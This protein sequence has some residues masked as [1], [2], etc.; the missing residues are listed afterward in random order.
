MADDDIQATQVGPSAE[1]DMP[2]SKGT[3]T[4]PLEATQ[5]FREPDEQASRLV[6]V[7]DQYLADLKAGRAPDRAQL[8]ADHPEL[9]EQLEACLAGIE[10]IHAGETSHAPKQLGE[11]RILREIGR[12]GMGAVYEAEQLSLRRRVALKVLRFGTVSDPEAIQRFQREAETVARLH[13]TNIVPIFAV[14]CER[15]VN[16]YAMQF[17]EGRSLDLVLKQRGEPADAQIVATWGLQAADA[18]AHAHARG[19]IHR[20]V[21]PSNLILDDAEGRLWLTDFGLAKRLDDV[22]LSMTG[23]LLGTPRYMSP[24]QAAAAHNKLD[25]RTDIYSLGA[26]LYELATGKPVFSGDSPH[27]VISQIITAEPTPPRKHRP[28]LPR[29]LDTIMMKCLSKEPG[30]RYESA[31]QLADD[32]RAFLEGR[33][34]AARRV[35]LVEQA[36]RWVKRQRRSVALTAGAVAITLLLVALTVAGSYAWHRSRLATAMLRTDFPPLVADLLR[37]GEAALPPVTVPTQHPV[38]TTAGEYELRLS[39]DNRLSETIDVTFVPRALFD[40]KYDLEDQ[41]LWG[42]LRLD[43][44]YRL[45][46]FASDGT[47]AAPPRVDVIRLTNDGLRCVWGTTG[48]D[49]WE[50]KLREPTHAILKDNVR[51]FWPWEYAGGSDYDRGLGAFDKR[52]WVVSLDMGAPSTNSPAPA[53]AT[54]TGWDFN[55]DGASDLVLAAQRQAWVLA[56]SGRDGEPLWVAARGEP[57]LHWNRGEGVVYPPLAVGDQNGDGKTELI[58][59]FVRAEP[60][61]PAERWVE[62]LSSADGKSLWRYDLAP[63]WF[64][65]AQDD[66][67]PY[68]LRWFYGQSGGF[69]S[70]GAGSGWSQHYRTRSDSNLERSGDYAY[71]PTEPQVVSASEP[72]LAL[73]AGAHGVRLDVKSGQPVEPPHDTGVHTGMQPRYGD[74][75]GDGLRDTLLIDRRPDK[76][77]TQRNGFTTNTPLVRLTAWSFVKQTILWRRDLEAAWPKQQEMNLLPPDWPVVADVNGDG[78]DDVLAPDG[79]TEGTNNWYSPPWGKVALLDGGSGEPFWRQQIFNLDQQLDYFT[80]GPDIDGDGRREVYVAALWGDG[81]NLFVDCLS[82]ADG[83]KLWR[84][85]QRLVH[86]ERIEAEYRLANL[87]WFAARGDG[88]PQ[89]VVTARCVQGEA[90]DRASFFSAGTGRLTHQAGQASELQAADL[91]AD[92]VEDLV[93]FRQTNVHN[94]DHGG[95]LQAVRGIGREAWRRGAIGPVAAGDLD[96]DGVR[97]LM[98]QPSGDALR[99]RSGATGVVL[100]Q[101]PIETSAYAYQPFAAAT[102]DPRH[103]LLETPRDLDGDGVPDL[104]VFSGESSVRDKQPILMALS[105]RQGALLWKSDF[106][107]QRSENAVLLDCRDLDGDGKVEV[108]FVAPCDYDQPHRDYFTGTN[109]V[110]L[111]LAVL[112]GRDGGVRWAQPLTGLQSQSGGAHYDLRRFWLDAA[113]ADLNGDGVEDVVLPA[114]RQAGA[115]PL[116]MV[117]HSGSDGQPLWKVPLPKIKDAQRSF[118]LVPPAAAGDLDGDGQPEVIAAA[119]AD[120]TALNGA[121]ATVVRLHA[122]DGKTG[123][124][125]WQWETPADHWKNEVDQNEPGRMKNRLRPIL[126]RRADGKQWVAIAL[127]ANDLQLHVVDDAGKSV[128][129]TSVEQST[130]TRGV[131]TWAIDAEGDGVDELIFLTENSLAL[132]RP[133]DLEN[134]V[135]QI[136]ERNSEIDRLLGVLPDETAPGRI[137]VLGGG[138][139]YSVRGVDAAT[140]S[141]V[142]TCVGPSPPSL[143]INEQTATLLN[144]PR[145]DVPP[146]ALYRF[147][148]QALVRRGVRIQAPS[149]D[150]LAFA[151]PATRTPITHDPRQLRPLPWA[152]QEFERQEMPK[153]AAWAV[154]YGITLA[155]I[156]MAFVGWM[157]RRRQWGMKTLLLAPA[158]VGLAMLA[159]LIS[160]EDN[161]FHSGANKFLVAFLGAGPPMF[162]LAT[163]AVWLSQGRWRR[164]V[165]WISVAVLTVVVIMTF[166]LFVLARDDVT[167]LQPGERYSWEGWY[168]MFPPVLYVMSWLLLFVVGG[169]LIRKLVRWLRNRPQKNARGAVA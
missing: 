12:G 109:D 17:I 9:A 34:I 128:S 46:R 6:G 103:E 21:K 41:T 96:G 40:Q 120:N 37:D 138:R 69:S 18:L 75:D 130:V 61:K 134:P 119:L 165:L 150:W 117:A 7:L 3:H 155:A 59:T 144:P 98:E 39:S 4:T 1:A 72:A 62:S 88:W 123:E 154:F 11:F 53:L 142:W 86:H 166:S 106:H 30:E 163:L 38:E 91:D 148:S 64:A 99:T 135:W 132:L 15:G 55:S 63:E 90:G 162:A 19:V 129:Q 145:K 54:A 127:W 112:D 161:D 76:V 78:R 10:F 44:S 24:E 85:E 57:S 94:W 32:L 125:R 74:F 97:D 137:V 80:V 23:A 101:A 114:Q 156:P 115:S 164:V 111:W 141:F 102:R 83:A 60:G 2:A 118:G 146:H 149:G 16:Y 29:D 158:V 70:G 26:S 131:R 113:Y 147:Q 56:I 49:R 140:G 13:H 36:T 47:P 157:V 51:L 108:V 169:R 67:V 100:W 65:V 105:G 77:I 52:P 25:H 68:D 126:V 28:S 116:D 95:V 82:G 153:L 20:D 31:R 81:A 151:R 33:P 42:D 93:L 27:D 50:L 124:T 84:A 45:A 35:S 89:L 133:D 79:S 143:S 104:L 168:F 121:W 87:A 22:T 66:D 107:A 136:A 110:Q 48:S 122:I 152:P 139:D 8:L 5:D 92:G 14:G 58:A 71:L 167:Q 43:R 160:P 73:V 159:F